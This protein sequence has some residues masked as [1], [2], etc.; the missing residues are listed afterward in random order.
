[1]FWSTF[2]CMFWIRIVI[3]G[4]GA[5]RERKLLLLLL[6]GGVLECTGVFRNVVELSGGRAHSPSNSPS[7]LSADFATALTP[8]PTSPPSCPRTLRP[9]S[10]SPPASPPACLSTLRPRSLSPPACPRTCPRT[11]TLDSV[12]SHLSSHSRLKVVSVCVC[13]CVYIIFFGSQN[14]LLC[15]Y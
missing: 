2:Y 5:Y 13:V 1:M 3:A 7:R 15:E 9:R 6:G 12:N 4:V 10:L 8:P 11:L 14:I